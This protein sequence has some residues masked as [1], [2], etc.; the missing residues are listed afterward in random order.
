MR[1]TRYDAGR[2]RVYAAE[3]SARKKLKDQYQR[4]ATLAACQ[5]FTDRITASP[6]WQAMQAP[7]PVRLKAMPRIGRK[8]WFVRRRSLGLAK[9]IKDRE[10]GNITFSHISLAPR[11]PWKAIGGGW[12][13]FTILHE[14]AHAAN[15]WQEKHGTGFLNT[16]LKLIDT[17]L[18]SEAAAIFRQAYLEHG[19]NLMDE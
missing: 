10:S 5:A 14:L 8:R 6:V 7:H 4:Y 16:H 9:F 2:H 13:N 3:R 15:T 11:E 17:A 1:T 18:G 19:V 12:D